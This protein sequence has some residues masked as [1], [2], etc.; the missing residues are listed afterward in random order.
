[1]KISD[2]PDVEN[3]KI[4]HCID[5]FVRPVENREILREFW[6]YKKTMEQLAESYHLSVTT[7]KRIIHEDGDR[8]LLK[9]SE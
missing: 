5:E 2:I 1:M 4:E 3:S 7:I 9:A 6:V 8:V